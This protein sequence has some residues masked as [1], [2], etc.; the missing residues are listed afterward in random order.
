MYTTCSVML[1][2]DYHYITS[3]LIFHACLAGY[4][5]LQALVADF[6]SSQPRSSRESMA[7]V[8]SGPNT[9]SPILLFP[10]AFTLFAKPECPSRV[11]T[12]R[13]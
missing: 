11:L 9:V 7:Q 13:N 10:L 6:P 5:E 2:L 4:S 12:S 8:A 1:S 3:S